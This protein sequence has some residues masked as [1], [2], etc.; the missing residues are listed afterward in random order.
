MFIFGPF[1][2]VDKE[3]KIAIN[4]FGEAIHDFS[5]PHEKKSRNH[6]KYILG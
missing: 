4:L 5:H 3:R 1:T 6:N 2:S